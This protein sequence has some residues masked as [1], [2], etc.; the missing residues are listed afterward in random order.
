MTLT[1]TMVIGKA[2][3]KI[4]MDYINNTADLDGCVVE[5]DK[6]TKL[7]DV[8]LFVDGKLLKKTT[9]GFI[10]LTDGKARFGNIYITEETGTEIIEAIK[11][12]H[13]EMSAQIETPEVKEE[14]TEIEEAKE[15]LAKVEA[16]TTEI[17]SEKEEK[18]WRANYNNLQNEGGEGYVPTRITLED[19]EKAKKTLRRS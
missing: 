14:A 17:L 8:E 4:T 3:I 7:T 9:E 12:M 11:E 18:Q 16:R 5:T 6:I 1:K 19:V 13:K 10:Y 15:V 2:T